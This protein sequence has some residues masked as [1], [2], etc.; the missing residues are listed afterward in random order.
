MVLNAESEPAERLPV[1]LSIELSAAAYR[2]VL[3]LLANG[4]TAATVEDLLEALEDQ[5]DDVLLQALKDVTGTDPAG[6]TF[7]QEIELRI[8]QGSA[9]VE[10]ADDAEPDPVE[11]FR[12]AWHDALT[13]NVHP[14]SELW[15]ALDAEDAEG[16]DETNG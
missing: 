8:V 3:Q 7:A 5:L 16:I 14:I 11:G 4:E 15:A 12:Q 1:R 2:A 10:T 9:V 13:G 6:N